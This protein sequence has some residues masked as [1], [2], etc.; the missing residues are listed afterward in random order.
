[1]VMPESNVEQPLTNCH[2]HIFT[3]DHVPPYLGKSFLPLGLAYVFTTPFIV[4]I[5]RA[6]FNGPYQWQFK[7]WYKKLAKKYYQL[8][9][10]IVRNPVARLVMTILAILICVNA[11]YILYDWIMLITSPPSDDSNVNAVRT[12]LNQYHTL[13]INPSTTVQISIILIVIL[14]IKSGRN[15]IFFLLKRFFKL[16]AILPGKETRKYLARYLSIGR[17]AFY[18]RQS[19]IFDKLKD[20][21]PVDTRFVILPMDM[22]FMG[23]GSPPT[24]YKKQMNDLVMLKK[25]HRNTA[26]PFVFIDPRRIKSQ[27]DFF[28][29]TV[30][31]NG[32]VVL[33]DCEVKE[34]I[35]ANK[36]SGFKIYPALG[37][38]P[39][40]RELLPVWKYAAQHNLPILT[41]CIRGTI[42]YRGAKKE[43]WDYHPVFREDNSN[44]S[45]HL[46]LPERKNQ[47]FSIN[48]T[49]PLN[50]LC[51]LK[52]PLLRKVIEQAN[53]P[54]LNNMFGYINV[55][56]P[57][58]RDLHNL[59]LC[60]G[61]FGGDD[62]WEKYFE[63][64]RDQYSPQ[65][66]Q[67]PYG[68]DFMKGNAKVYSHTRIARMWRR[69]DWYSIICSI[70]LQHPNVYSDISYIIH[71]PNIW[72]LLKDTLDRNPVAAGARRLSD[73]ILFGTDFYVVRNH[74]SEKQLLAEMEH[75]LSITDVDQIARLNPDNF[76]K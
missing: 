59:K 71:N 56:S 28:K 65:I 14:F 76:V 62:E 25:N 66:L 9:M 64:D 23:A 47:D 43:E 48:F 68:I 12:W 40:E 54:K 75:Q 37:Y 36:F 53:D 32:D 19:D 8:K 51:L 11:F 74:K 26:L 2:T 22:E 16:F 73:G 10:F 33:E 20:Q 60:F 1:M 52:E 49:H 70:M 5:F 7:P 4:G 3:S 57:L 35:E 46:L 50:Y 27:P 6:W 34:Y 30:D 39:F 69:T 13:L 17:F 29:Y 67:K 45:S 21:Y 61:H 18:K 24:E 38:Y 63:A 72:S 42:F 15:L 58:T 41:H 55:N 31:G 44:D